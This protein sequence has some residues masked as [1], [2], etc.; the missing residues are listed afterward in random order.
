[1]PEGSNTIFEYSNTLLLSPSRRIYEPE[2]N[3]PM[4]VNSKKAS[5][6]VSNLSSNY[7]AIMM[8]DDG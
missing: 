2:A 6:L 1:M 4:P 3:T 5:N 8:Q 7:H